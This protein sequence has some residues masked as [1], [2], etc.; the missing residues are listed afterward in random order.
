M[1]DLSTA[2]GRTYYATVMSNILN[3]G[4]VNFDTT[5]WDGFEIL[6]LMPLYS[7]PH[8]AKTFGD[9]MYRG[10]PSPDWYNLGW[11]LAVGQDWLAAMEETHRLTNPQTAVECSFMAPGLG[12]WR[13]VSP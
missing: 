12:P 3:A 8:S 4:G 5:Q 7:F 11:P 2:H 9:Q 1:F 6:L 13:P 10:I